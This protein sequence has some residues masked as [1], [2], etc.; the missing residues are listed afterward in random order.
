MQPPLRREQLAQAVDNEQF[1][2]CMLLLALCVVHKLLDTKSTWQNSVHLHS[3]NL[4]ILKIKLQWHS[5]NGHVSAIYG[6]P[7]ITVCFSQMNIM[8][9]PTQNFIVS[10]RKAQ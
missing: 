6:I 1:N 3:C 4:I 5:G 2:A 7:K 9:N 10:P 8:L